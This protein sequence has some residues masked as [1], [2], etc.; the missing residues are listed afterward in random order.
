LQ[1]ELSNKLGLASKSSGKDDD[2]RITV[3]K[4]AEK[5]RVATGAEGEEENVPMLR[6]GQH[7]IHELQKYIEEYPPNEI[8]DMESRDTGSSLLYSLT[9]QRPKNNDKFATDISNN[10]QQSDVD[11]LV[12]AFE[13][14]N[15]PD[16]SI[17]MQK[18]NQEV[19]VDLKQ[20]RQWYKNAQ[21]A[22]NRHPKYL[23]MKAQRQALPSYNY[24]SQICDAIRSN[25]VVIISGDTGCGKSKNL[26][27][28]LNLLLL[29]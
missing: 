3:R 9:K 19:R 1:H 24:A 16:S 18:E 2:R 8:E 23:A 22:R 26:F 7:G 20:R 5:K 11:Y 4:V 29:A 25:S 14:V 15:A 17:N 27:H 12:R 6:I 21:Q 28:F 13:S 10:K